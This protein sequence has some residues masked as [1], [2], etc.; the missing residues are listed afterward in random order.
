FAEIGGSGFE[1]RILQEGQE[2]RHFHGYTKVTS[3]FALHQSECGGKASHGIHRLNGLLKHKVRAHLK[4]LL[5]CGGAVQNGEGHGV[6]VAGSLA[7]FL[8]NVQTAFK[9]VAINDHGVVFLGGENLLATT[10][11]AANNDH[12]IKLVHDHKDTPKAL[13]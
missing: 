9:I 13:H 1:H 10:E 4:C 11:S 7:Q 2:G 6:L 12:D 5:S 3:P 8:Q